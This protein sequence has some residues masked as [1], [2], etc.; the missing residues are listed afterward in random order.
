MPPRRRDVKN[1]ILPSF[2]LA[3]LNIFRHRLQKTFSRRRQHDGVNCVMT[4]IRHTL[5]IYFLSR[6]KPPSAAQFRGDGAGPGK[7]TSLTLRSGKHAL[8]FIGQQAAR[9]ARIG[10]IARLKF[11]FHRCRVFQF[12]IALLETFHILEALETGD[13]FI[14]LRCALVRAEPFKRGAAFFFLVATDATERFI[15]EGIVAKAAPRQ[16][17][18][19]LVAGVIGDETVRRNGAVAIDALE[20][21]FGH[22]FKA[23]QFVI[24]DIAACKISGVLAPLVLDIVAVLNALR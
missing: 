12:K 7:N 4:V 15:G 20:M 2:T 24:A 14:P 6:F 1:I 21:L 16:N 5:A 8:Q 19:D 10:E 17:V 9:P 22:Q 23:H 18:I 13:K 3:L 11:V